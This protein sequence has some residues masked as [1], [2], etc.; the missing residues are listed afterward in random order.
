MSFTG[1]GWGRQGE[2]Q[3]R[4]RTERQRLQRIRSARR[5]R[6]AC[7][8]LEDRVVMAVSTWSGAVSS[9]WSVAGNWDVAAAPGNSL[10]FPS[11]ATRLIST[12]DLT[13]G[14]SFPSLTISGASYTIG[15]N[16]AAIAAI[17][18]SPTTGVNTIS[19][20]L[21]VSGLT[22]VVVDNTSA[23][24]IAEGALSGSGGLSKLGM[25]TLS[26]TAASPYSGTI[27]A[28]NGILNVDGGLGG[29][30]V[31]L[32]GA[33]LSGTGT[34][35]GINALSGT[36]QPGGANP[37]ILHDSGSM[38][39]FSNTIYSIALN[40]T[41]AGAGYSQA[42]VGGT[43]N[44]GSAT[45]SGTLGFTPTGNQLFTILKNNGA[46]AISNT[47]QGLPEGGVT[48]I[49]GE[50]FRISYVGGG[51]HDVVL[52]H[53][54]STNVV[55][56]FTPANPALAQSVTLTAKVT[57]SAGS[58][59]PTGSVQFFNGATSIGTATLSGGIGSLSLT[60]L[61]A[62]NNT[63]TAKYLS[64]ALFTTSSSP[65][66]T[67]PVGLRATTAT[68]SSAPTGSTVFGQT[69]TFGVTV[70]PVAGA[71]TPTGTVFFFSGSLPIGNAVLS[72]GSASIPLRNL[73]VGTD[74]VTAHYQGDATFGAAV[75]AVNSR[76]VNP[77]ATSVTLTPIPSS[78]TPG[79]P[80]T[81]TAQV[82][83]T[84][85][86]SGTPT[87]AVQFFN[88]TTLLGSTNL[89]SGIASLGVTNLPIGT[90]AVTAKY[91][92]DS[93]F[94]TSTSAPSNVTITGTT[95]TTTLTSSAGS[96]LIGQPVT[97]TA[98]VAAGGAGVGTPTGRVQF[99]DG[100]TVLA[101]VPL[102]TGKAT[103]TT[104]SLSAGAHTITAK[105]Q[106]N[107]TFAASTST[108]V[109]QNVNLQ[110]TTV[111]LTVSPS[112]KSTLGQAVTLTSNVHVIAPGTATPTGSVSFFAN[113]TLLGTVSLTNGVATLTT[114][115]LPVGGSTIWAQYL[116]DA[117]HAA[118]SSADVNQLVGSP[119][120][121]YINQLY[122]DIL[123][124]PVNP[125]ELQHG[126]AA[127]AK[128]VK[129]L[130]LVNSI[131]HTF[132]ARTVAV[133]RAYEAYLSRVP[134]AAEVS[135]TIAASRST[136]SD[137]RVPILALNEF[138]ATNGNGTV[139]GY[140]TAL[141]SVAAGPTYP[142]FRN[143]MFTSELLGGTPRTK[144]VE[145]VLHSAIAATAQ[146]KALYEFYLGRE[147]KA[148]ELAQGVGSIVR[149][150]S[151]RNVEAGLL[152]SQEF[153]NLVNASA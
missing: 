60:T 6:F 144:V 34:V 46:S 84:G 53:L 128:G 74:A 12:N 103:F 79:L 90:N 89:S 149:G 52:T 64:D 70:A 102:A 5:G 146:V 153:Y 88:G 22:S 58:A 119:A 68:L 147:P 62:G 106:G 21:D 151:P 113:W 65:S 77:A 18:D 97:F 116:G 32:T 54:V 142:A 139:D 29:A 87:G 24:L 86:G 132:E 118:N 109:T 100:A 85:F 94:S 4:G 30:Q 96:T 152:A 50:S 71:G 95:S 75:S 72:N 122:L 40:G 9:L 78:T 81:L 150:G 136:G 66:A 108:A 13:A 11:G 2:S 76:T 126:T 99:L 3:G 92:G 27:N 148:G 38:A 33:T 15:G 135:R 145:Q 42:A 117:L 56:T 23:T 25:G 93:N 16:S 98:S 10:V 14:S 69:V 43:I 107:A 49:G 80:V 131:L 19:L 129:R 110:Q 124:R 28:S 35:G 91:V 47:F 36:V 111:G 57:P 105:Y 115:A 133:Q 82:F 114:S 20:P 73:P 138:V 134:S 31:S 39:L 48:S 143:P 137:V 17:D 37:G 83:A 104:S 55:V 101:T 26:L 130:T 8:Q 7:E 120:Q 141:A 45:L 1:L 121:L 51:G 123:D 63:I 61:P 41:V 140:L 59:I 44:L 127:L 125:T 67:V 112:G